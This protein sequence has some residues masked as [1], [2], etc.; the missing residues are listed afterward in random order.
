[1]TDYEKLLV[2]KAVPYSPSAC[3]MA[4]SIA[5]RLGKRVVDSGV[6]DYRTLRV[7]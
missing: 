2:G 7:E 5:A 1:M 4:C 3:A 6:F